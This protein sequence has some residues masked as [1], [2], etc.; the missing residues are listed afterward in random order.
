VNDRRTAGGQLFTVGYEGKTVDSFLGLLTASAV[1]VLV[2]VRELPLSRKPGFS[3]TRLQETLAEHGIEYVSMRSLGS[4]R[5]LRK[6]LHDGGDY[7]AFFARYREHLEQ[8][9]GPL[10]ALTGLVTGHAVCLMCYEADPARCHRSAIA[11][12]LTHSNGVPLEVQHL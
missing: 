7:R 1:T 2:D 6:Q 10:A 8:Q 5:D 11:K 4:P 9:D 3:K 12:E